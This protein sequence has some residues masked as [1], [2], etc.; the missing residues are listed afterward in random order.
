LNSKK[1]NELKGIDM[2]LS[3]L[4]IQERL[5]ALSKYRLLEMKEIVE[6]RISNIK[7]PYIPDFGNKENIEFNQD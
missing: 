3:K 4:E 7:E 2:T 5:R 6:P 1:A